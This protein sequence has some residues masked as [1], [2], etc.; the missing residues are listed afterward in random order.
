MH[1]FLS[2]L[3]HKIRFSDKKNSKNLSA[4]RKIIHS[5]L[6]YKP[7]QKQ[8]ENF[9]TTSRRG[10]LSFL[11]YVPFFKNI[12]RIS[13]IVFQ[14]YCIKFC[15][16]FSLFSIYFRLFSGSGKQTSL[17][18]EPQH[19]SPANSTREKQSSTQHQR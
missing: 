12:L 10:S 4:I 11:F 9:P 16:S 6:L 1:F 7:S 15:S 3:Q 5:K 17:N 8:V 19:K 2:S 13:D 18:H 14:N